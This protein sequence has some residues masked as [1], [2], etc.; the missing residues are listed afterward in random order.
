MYRNPRNRKNAADSASFFLKKINI[1]KSYIRTLNSLTVWQQTDLG[2]DNRQLLIHEF[3]SVMVSKPH[4]HRMKYNMIR[5]VFFWTQFCFLS[6]TRH[7]PLCIITFYLNEYY[8]YYHCVFRAF[9]QHL[10]TNWSLKCQYLQSISLPRR[11][12]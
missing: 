2:N 6:S 10:F 11:S 5:D 7:L 12:T 1:T 3:Q 8:M 9:V 4:N